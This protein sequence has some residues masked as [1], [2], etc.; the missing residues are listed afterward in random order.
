M[1]SNEEIHNQHQQLRTKTTLFPSHSNQHGPLSFIQRA[2]IV[3]LYKDGQ[4]KPEIANKIGTSLP[5][6][7]HWIQH[8]EK[9]NIT[10][11]KRSG[12]KRKTTSEQDEEIICYADDIKFTGGKQIKQELDLEI[13]E[14]YN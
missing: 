9:E 4:S 6:V 8:Y 1:I 14:S 5:T 2:G 13:F 7:R 11:E 12:R 3:T 10:N